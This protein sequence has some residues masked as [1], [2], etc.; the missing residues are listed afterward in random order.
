ML[1]GYPAK[2]R[3]NRKAGVLDGY[4]RCPSPTGTARHRSTTP[5][6][7]SGPV[8]G[9]N[10]EAPPLPRP[11]LWMWAALHRGLSKLGRV[12]GV[13][14]SPVQIER[15]RRMGIENADWSSATCVHLIC[16]P[17][18]STWCAFYSIST[19]RSRNNQ[20]CFAACAWLKPGGRLVATLG[21]NT[22]TGTECDWL[23][24]RGATMYWSHSDAATYRVWLADAG[25]AITEEEFIRRNGRSPRFRSGG[26]LAGEQ[27]RAPCAQPAATTTLRSPAL[28]RGTGLRGARDLHQAASG[29][30]H[31][32]KYSAGD[33]APRWFTTL[34]VEIVGRIPPIGSPRR[35]GDQPLRSTENAGRSALN[36][37]GK[38][39]RVRARVR[40]FVI[41]P[42]DWKRCTSRRGCTPHASGYVRRCLLTEHARTGIPTV[43]VIRTLVSPGP[44]SGISGPVVH[45][46][47]EAKPN[48]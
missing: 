46:L 6:G 40:D 7:S 10:G 31:I 21:A 38:A 26:R 43:P 15:R 8:T 33:G 9:W 29:G 13:D 12:V 23:G 19:C 20:N 5:R 27:G 16:R 22:W 11:G 39:A 34:S 2:I 28:R 42:V 47:Q 4:D 17:A 14:L 1:K 44:A 41:H 36:R 37:A 24:V 3:M 32:M 48:D 18:R 30:S 25:F 45:H 35:D